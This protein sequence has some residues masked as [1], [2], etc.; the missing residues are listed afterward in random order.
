[1]LK[2]TASHC[3]NDSAI[4]MLL[5]AGINIWGQKNL[6]FSAVSEVDSK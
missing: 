6:F 4:V 1:M 3:Q 5:L 2:H